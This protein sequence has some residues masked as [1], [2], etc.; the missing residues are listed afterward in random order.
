M[1]FA[2]YTR[3]SYYLLLPYTFAHCTLGPFCTRTHIHGH[4]RLLCCA[5]FSLSTDHTVVLESLRTLWANIET[6]HTINIC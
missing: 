4:T 1:L 6:K 5:A 3:T 2:G